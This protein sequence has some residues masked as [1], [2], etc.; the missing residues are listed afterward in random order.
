M[1]VFEHFPYV[2]FHELNLDWIVQRLKDVEQNTTVDTVA[3]AGVA[4]NAQDISDLT[5]TV[6]NNANTAHN[7]ALAAQNTA[8]TASSTA[9]TANNTANAATNTA[10]NTA[11]ALTAFTKYFVRGDFTLAAGGTDTYDIMQHISGSETGF[12]FIQPRGLAVNNVG[13]LYMWRTNIAK[14]TLWL[15]DLT[16]GIT[17][18]FAGQ[19]NSS[20]L[21]SN[22][23]TSDDVHYD[24]LI[25]K[26][27]Y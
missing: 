21:V 8:N 14:T 26:L 4:Q 10:N 18:S 19:M 9:T 13:K 27:Y 20:G 12:I 2:N 1:G 7:E 17:S 3:R 6:T 15:T 11:A 24:F 22:S 25:Y 23:A 5:T 16:S